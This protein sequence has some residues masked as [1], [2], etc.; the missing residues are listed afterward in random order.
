MENEE[1]NSTIELIKQTLEKIRPFIQRDGGD[2]SFDSYE[3][4]IVYVN[5]LGACAGCS[6]I[7]DTL[8][9]GVETIIMEE[10]PGVIAVRLA[11]DKEAI[12]EALKNGADAIKN[13]Q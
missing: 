7:E 6:L 13:P 5:F 4:G 11:S 3:D 1:F 10:V 2:V 9:E 12:K 8:Y